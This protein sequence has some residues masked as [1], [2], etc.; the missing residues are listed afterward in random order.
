[1][2]PN[3]SSDWPKIEH[4]KCELICCNHLCLPQMCKGLFCSISKHYSNT[5][6]VG[7]VIGCAVSLTSLNYRS[8]TIQ[9]LR[10]AF[11]LLSLPSPLLATFY[12]STTARVQVKVWKRRSRRSRLLED[13]AVASTPAWL[14][15]LEAGSQRSKRRVHLPCEEAS[16]TLCWYISN[17]CCFSTM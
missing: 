13:P 7:Q 14:A 3:S 15:S 1:M 5:V 12:W 8:A 9:W 6:G 17:T 2:N 10:A 11:K 16:L 4:S